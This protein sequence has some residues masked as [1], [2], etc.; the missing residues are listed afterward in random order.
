MTAYIID[1]ETTGFTNP[2]VIELAYCRRINPVIESKRFKPSKEIELGALATH[3]ILPQ[4]LEGCEPSSAAKLPSDCTYII[5][6][7]VD[8]D[9]QALGQPPIR[10]ICTLALARHLLPHL[11]SHTIGSLMY[12]F[13]GCTEAVRFMLREAHSAVADVEFCRRILA[14]LD[15]DKLS[16]F[17]LWEF[18]E[19]ARIPAKMTFGKHR[20]MEIARLPRDYKQWMLK[21]PDMD[22]YLL[23]AVRASL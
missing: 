12:H 20:G 22:P 6:H 15:G 11:D 21:Q 17:D 1:T 19:K 18:S 3:H 14:C 2:E 5:G 8:F 7:N 10:R 23:K 13:L 9:W 4:E 16:D